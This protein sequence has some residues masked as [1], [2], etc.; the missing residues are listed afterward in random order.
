MNKTD[1]NTNYDS[2]LASFIWKNAND[3][4]GDF[5]HTDM[6]K[7]ILPFTVL[8]RLE[9]VLEETHQAVLET[10]Q[11]YKDLPL[12]SL[13]LLLKE[14]S[15]HPFYNL[16]Q[17]NLANLGATQ[18]LSNL[19][20]Y[21]SQFSPNAQAIFNNFEF[22][23]ILARLDKANLLFKICQNFAKID[24]HPN[25]VSDR[26]MSNVY[27]HLIAKFGSEVGTGAEDFMTPRDIVHL[28]TALLLSPDDKLF[29]QKQ[30][31]IRTLYDQT[32]GTAGFL[33]DMMNYIGGFKQ[34][35]KI[36]PTLVPYGQE[37]QPETYA[38]ALGN[39]LLKHLENDPSRDL[40]ANIRLGSTLSNDQ[41]SGHRFHYQCSNPPFGMSWGKDA[42]AVKKETKLGQRF[43]AGL[44]N[45]GD[46]SMLFLQNLVSKLES[47]ENG[48]G[49]GAIVL[50][51]S[52]LFNGDAGS[53]ESEIRR[54]ILENDLLEAIIALPTDIFF[55]TGIGTYIWLISNR[56]EPQRQGKVQLIDATAMASSMRK[57]EGKKSKYIDEE[58]IHK[59]CQI[60]ADFEQS[61]ISKIFD[62]QEFGYRKI[63]VQRP[64]RCVI[65]L[66]QT[67]LEQFKSSKE[68]QKLSTESQSA[69]EHFLISHFGNWSFEHFINQ[70]IALIPVPRMTKGIK[71]S[72]I[73][74]FGVKD[75]NAPPVILDGVIQ[76]DPDLSDFERVPLNQDIHEY[77][78]TEV[79]PHTPDAVIDPDDKD[80]KDKALGKVG[81]EINFNRYFYQFEQPRHPNEILTE[82]RALSSEV[83]EL[84]AEI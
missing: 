50:S 23:T 37:L 12:D 39:M 82:M 8:R 56:K 17:Y 14:A 41:F 7:I 21:I 34:Q 33:T 60:Y 76:F 2:T 38:V 35:D 32:C 49:R 15:Q 11:T 51:G 65:Q 30:G 59:I 80:Q 73:K 57:N 63:K 25:V 67:T 16:S 1:M 10:A 5:P 58:A 54:F 9:C 72:L 81:Y 40:S 53:G 71:N 68:F 31:L 4:W 52:P 61:D 19:E 29:E 28:A 47:P 66:N 36:A 43:S 48:G 46:G 44:P 26:T 24:L 13:D 83:A 77:L 20:D 84:L 27:E 79:L 78:K 75:S 70:I 42:E 69:V 3:L 18:T 55:R 45:V 62:Y 64:L 22:S 74:S 6:G